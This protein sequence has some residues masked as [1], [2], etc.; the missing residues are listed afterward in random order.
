MPNSKPNDVLTLRDFYEQYWHCRDFEINNLWQRSIFL[1]TFLVLSFT[2][3]G[4]FFANA[5]L[6]E[7]DHILN[8]LEYSES[9]IYKQFFAVFLAIVG[10]F[11]SLLW[12][13]MAKASKAWVE[14]YERA[15]FMIEKKLGCDSTD[16]N[17]CVSFNYHKIPGYHYEDNETLFD[18]SFFSQKGGCFSPSKTNIFIGQTSLIIWIVIEFVH[19]LI[20]FTHT[21]FC[22][23]EKKE[24][25]PL[26]CGILLSSF[27]IL[28]QMILFLKLLKNRLH[29]DTLEGK[30]P[31]SIKMDKITK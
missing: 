12:I 27:I 3:Y 9:N 1:G 7:N 10:C 31:K 2:G 11:F 17:N 14:V 24:C 21:V 15:I 30:D 22:C 6:G 28:I 26:G 29:S 20:L 8:L 19:L 13:A 23:C 4:V 5:F 18:N 25:I 16:F